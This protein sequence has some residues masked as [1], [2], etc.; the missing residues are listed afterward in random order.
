MD[1]YLEFRNKYSEFYYNSYNIEEN[2]DYILITYNFEIKDLMEFNPTIKIPKDSHCS[3]DRKTLDAIVFNVGLSEIAS[4]WKAT[5]SPKIIIKC[6]YLDDFRKNWLK[7]LLFNGLGEFFYVNGIK[8]DYDDFVTIESTGEDKKVNNTK[9]YYGF[10]VAVGGGK[11][12]ITSL[13]ILSD[14]PNKKAFIINNRKVCFDSAKLAGLED[15]DIINVERCFDKKII[16]LNKQGFLNG[17]TPLSSVIAFISY[18]TAYIHGIKNIVLS[19]ESSANEASVKGTNINHQYS[20]SL[21]FENDFREY[22]SKYLISDI[23]YFSLLRP[24]SELQIM[25]IFTRYPKYFKH[26]ISCNNGGKSK[27]IGRV[28]GWCCNCSKCLFIYIIMS[29][30]LSQEEM[31]SIFGENLLDK[32]SMLD[33]FLE[34]LGKKE[35][36]PF[37]CVGTID[38]VSFV[39]NNLITKNDGKLPYLLEYYKSNYEVVKPNYDLL[40]NIDKDNNLDSYLLDIVKGALNN[41]R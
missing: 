3:Y 5:C 9:E 37:E 35:S 36:K 30:F 23:S 39:V 2:D 26:F 38:E 19:N 14:V 12:S 27:N 7:K 21:E 11:D 22:V 41:D 4:Y 32:E 29:N 34:L 15:E 8:P 40:S 24:L 25:S 20:K 18:L 31:V 28:D 13:E 10:L 33:Y 6:G 16:E 1:K 17:H